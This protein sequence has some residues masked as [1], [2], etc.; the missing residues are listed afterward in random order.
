MFSTEKDSYEEYR[1]VVKQVTEKD[2]ELFTFHK[3]DLD[4]FK[5]EALKKSEKINQSNHLD[6]FRRTN[7]PVVGNGQNLIKFLFLNKT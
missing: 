2:T 4:E 7:I 1:E 5:A 3:A 6:L